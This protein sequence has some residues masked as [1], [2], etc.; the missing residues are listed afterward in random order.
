MDYWLRGAIV[1]L[2]LLVTGLLA[3]ASYTTLVRDNLRSDPWVAAQEWAKTNTPPGSLFLTPDR[4]GGF[5]IHSERPVV[6]EWRDGTQ[7]Y[8]SAAFGKRWW[9][10]IKSIRKDMVVDSSGES[11]VDAGTSLDQMLDYKI[12]ELINSLPTKPNYIVLPT[13]AKER[14]LKLACSAGF[15]C[16]H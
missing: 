5:R 10:T 6:C 7:A 11:F 12:L 8:F 4:M 2:G 16:Q 14:N 15:Y 13:A 3:T 9:E 1:A